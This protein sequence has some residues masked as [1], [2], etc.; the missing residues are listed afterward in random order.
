MMG[1]KEERG[2]IGHTVDD[3]FKL[4]DT[5][6]ESGRQFLIRMSYIELYNEMISDLLVEV[7]Y[8]ML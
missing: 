6:L 7:S 1:S 2:L 3:I 4:F 8:I 5:Y